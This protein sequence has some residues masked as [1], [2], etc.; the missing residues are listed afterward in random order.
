[1]SYGTG[2]I[3]AVPAHDERDHEFAIRYGL[4]IR[5]VIAPATGESID[6]QSRAWVDKDGEDGREQPHQLVVM[7]R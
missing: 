4:P 1:M 3:M 7:H 6:V 5:Q 2:A